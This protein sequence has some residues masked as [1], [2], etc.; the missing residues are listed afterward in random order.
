MD[1]ATSAHDDELVPVGLQ[2]QL[3]VDDYVISRKQNV[4]RVLGTPRK[5]GVVVRASVPTDFHPIR[6]FPDGLP[7]TDHDGIGHRTS[8]LWNEQQRLFQMLYR[9]SSEDTT[10]YAESTDGIH[11][12]K[13]CIA[14]DGRSNLVTYRDRNRGTFYEASFV[15]DPTVPWG[16]PE[17]YKAAYNPGNTMCAIAHSA[18]GRHWTGYNNGNSVTGRAADTQNQ[19]LWDPVGYRYLLLTR[20]DLGSKGGRTEVRATRI[21]AHEKGN[22]ILSHPGAWK[23]LAT[24]AINDP[25]REMTSAGVDVRQMEAMTVWVY[26]NVYFGLM[27]VLT[28]GDL[29]GGG[30]RRTA[31]EDVRHETDVIDFFIGTSRDAAN[32]DMSWVHNRQPLIERGDVGSFDKSRIM[33]ASEIVTHGDEHWIYYQGDDCQHH[34]ARPVGSRGGQIGLA[35]LRLDGF[36]YLE[37]HD[38]WG[39]VVTKPFR[40]EG[41]TLA[42]NVD[43]SQGSFRVEI[44]DALGKPIPGFSDRN[45]IRYTGSDDARLQLRWTNRA[46][47]VALKGE[48]IRLRF[49]LCNARLFA[50]Q[51]LR[52]IDRDSVEPRPGP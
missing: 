39:Q 42:V 18:D 1:M 37:V 32:F 51:I 30:N 36:V 41:D 22:D 2:K 48:L 35:A 25:A 31:D 46:N 40:L 23:T 9:A 45:A 8:V 12:T 28:A 7:E 4:S 14:N 26:E 6:Q 19:I 15:I 16:H 13:P 27:R 20:T 3:L 44:L 11:W 34:G 47:L 52:K 33:A 43:A 10:A 5:V 49:H 29:M 17:K 21:M 24:I 38:H 50:F